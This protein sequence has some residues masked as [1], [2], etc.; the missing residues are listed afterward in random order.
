MTTKVIRRLIV[1]CVLLL[2]GAIP[3]SAQ[4]TSTTASRIRSGGTLPSTCATADIF[5]LTPGVS[6]TIQQYNCTAANTWTQITGGGSGTVTSVSVVTANGVSGSVATATTTPA[7]TLSLG[8]ITP[9]T[10]NGLTISSSTGTLAIA[11][12][13]TATVSNTL[14]FTGTDSSSVAFGA[15]GTVVYTTTAQTLT[16]KTLTSSTN[17]LGG[18]TMTLGSDADGDTYYRS[19]GVL[20]RLAKGTA[21]QQLRMNAGATA[22]EW[23][24]ASSSGA[25]TALD[26]LASVAINTSLLTGAGVAANFTATAPA[27]TA[28]AQA[29]T[30][31]TYTASAAVAGSSNAG[32]ANGGSLNFVAGAAARLTSGNGNGGDINFTPGALIGSGSNGAVIM[33]DDRQFVAAAKGSSVTLTPSIT[34]KGNLTTGWNGSSANQIVTIANGVATMGDVNVEHRYLSS[35]IV[36][37]TS[38]AVTSTSLD[39]AMA[40]PS[41][42]LIEI[43]NGTVGTYR[44]IKIRQLYVDQTITPGGTTGNQTINKAAGTVNIAAA[45]TSVTVT[46]SLCT[47]NSTVYAVV[48][49]NDATAYI[50]NVVP[51]AGSFTITLGAAATAEV[52]V[53]FQV[54]NL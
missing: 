36:G 1:L 29:G 12:G 35:L 18:V 38:G 49:T 26:N 33:A 19:G 22:P 45:G 2:A 40:R 42:G 43:N 37:W 21:L 39:T 4:S 8:A 7:I 32:A 34:F 16:N 41:A 11:N 13:K 15:G 50:K 48:R 6:G 20:T 28:S 51:T 17:V 3:L 27:Q 44:D 47:A 31:G 53:G 52:S 5:Y 14:T 9:T 23:A 10:V 54:V 46:N 25:T 30:S 24:T